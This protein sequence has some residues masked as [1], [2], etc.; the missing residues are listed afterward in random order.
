VP[1]TRSISSVPL[2]VIALLGWGFIAQ[3]RWH[4]LHPE[5][6]AE[7]QA[8]PAPPVLAYL[9]L[10]QERKGADRGPAGERYDHRS[11]GVAILDE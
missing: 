9:Q 4:A 5:P 8:L 1:R 3:L 6:Q 10:T 7:A 11:P 2:L